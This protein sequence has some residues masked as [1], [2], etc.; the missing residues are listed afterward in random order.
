VTI[1]TLLPKYDQRQPSKGVYSAIVYIDGTNIIAED[2]NGAIISSGVAGTNDGAVIN[3]AIANGFGKVFLSAGSYTTAATITLTLKK[4]IVGAGQDATKITYTG[5][6][7]LFYVDGSTVWSNGIVISDMSIDAGAK[8][9]IDIIGTNPYVVSQSNFE[10][11]YITNC[12]YGIYLEDSTNGVIYNCRFADITIEGVHGTGATD[13][14][15]GYGLYLLG[16]IY[17]TFERIQIEGVD[18]YSYAIYSLGRG[19][20]FNGVAIDGLIYCGGSSCTWNR[21]DI[22]WPDPY[23]ITP[24]DTDLWHLAGDFHTLTDIELH[25]I[26][27]T[28]CP[29]GIHVYGNGHIINNVRSYGPHY[30]T[31]VLDVS[32]TSS[33]T[34]ININGPST[35]WTHLADGRANNWKFIGCE[36]DHLV[37]RAFITGFVADSDVTTT[38][39]SLTDIT[40]LS[41]PIPAS[42]IWSF[43][44]LIDMNSSTG[45]NG[46]Q[47]AVNVPTSA[48]IE[49]S[50][51]GTTTG[52]TATN[53]ARSSSVNTA[54]T[55]I[56]TYAGDGVVR[57]H[58][59]VVNST[60]AGLI[61]IRFLKVTSGTA[62]IYK[63][64]YIIGR[65][66]A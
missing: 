33:G 31:Y 65:R 3:A 48:T 28:K 27:A 14:N 7:K 62:R 23:T 13:P 9:A 36:F 35:Y 11:L 45:A 61:Q 25:T 64:S 40:G 19:C 57:I 4:G 59:T 66:L 16:C 52:V 43:E 24:I 50:Q 41:I 58:G 5:T 46:I 54:N 30:C 60:S 38:G 21:V 20:D 34:G 53:S 18:G 47:F 51:V 32:S 56:C 42:Q 55:A 22:E 44:A 63:G 17:N 49:W 8:T 6:T 26:D 15:V 1:T 37:N 39:Q 12:H 29:T 10:I 2:V